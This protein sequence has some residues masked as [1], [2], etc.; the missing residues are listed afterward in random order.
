MMT[1]DQ[2]VNTLTTVGGFAVVGKWL[3][4]GVEKSNENLPV[5][6]KAIEEQGIAIKELFA[7][8]NEHQ[9]DIDQLKTTHRL[10]G[11]DEPI[12]H[13]RVTDRKG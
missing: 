13:R 4:R 6:L 7:S 9:S 3:A 2:I 1:L 10:R 5:M 12:P 11:C 8:R